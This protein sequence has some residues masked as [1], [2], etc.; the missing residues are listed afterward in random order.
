MKKIWFVLL[1]LIFFGIMISGKI[2]YEN[3]I[4]AQGKQAKEAFEKQIKEDERKK[5]DF[6]N[7]LNPENENVTYV[8]FLQYRLLK[9]SVSK[10]SLL[11]SSVTIGSGASNPELSWAG[12]LVTNLGEIRDNYQR[13]ELFN[14]GVGGYSTKNI[15]NNKIV[16]QVIQDNPDLVIFE[17]SIL[18]NHGQ[19][20][21][22][23]DT[24]DEIQ[25][26][27]DKIKSALPN[28]EILYT[29][30]NPSS[31]KLTEVNGL[32]LTYNDY[33]NATKTFIISKGWNYVDI[34]EGMNAKINQQKLK[35]NDVL[36]DGVHPNDEGYKIWFETLY[37]YMKNQKVL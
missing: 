21:T 34:Y 4:S 8:D 26:I 9:N 30:P 6:I 28:T 27:T 16:D 18:N 20:I 22:I 37:D 2:S 7:N 19:S 24:N 11:G 10:I 5:Q 1:T 14:H 36:L 25:A 15:I 35:L 23:K 3:K 31:T 32:G 13:V 33:L 17:T 12:R 29:S